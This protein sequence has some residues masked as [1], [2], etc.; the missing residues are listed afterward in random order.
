MKLTDWL[1]TVMLPLFEKTEDADLFLSASDLKSVEVPE[2]IQKAFASKYLTRERAATDDEII[3]KAN[4]HARGLVFGSVD[5]KLKKILPM[6]S[7]EDQ[8]MITQEPDTLVK[9]E[10]LESALGNLSKSDDVKKANETFRKKESEFHE[11]IS[12]LEASTKEKEVNFTKQLNEY[13]LDYALRNK[14]SSFKL[15]PEFSTDK[16]KEFLASSTIDFLKKN[17]ILEFDEKNQSTIHLR[18]NVDGT[19]ADVYEGNTKLTLEDVMKK[20]YEPYIE[21]NNAGG[22]TTPPHTPKPVVVQS[23]KPMTLADMQRANAG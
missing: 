14:V 4:V 19:V 12:A 11:K 9:L 8:A 16:H 2:E 21:K 20:E 15:A 17:Y 3:R 5:Q 18:K 1:K 6:L 23:D 10:K 7:A 13:K 22:G